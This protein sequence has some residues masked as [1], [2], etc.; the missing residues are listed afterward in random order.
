MIWNGYIHEIII[1][2]FR[3]IYILPYMYLHNSVVVVANHCVY[4]FNVGTVLAIIKQLLYLL[5]YIWIQ[6]LNICYILV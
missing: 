6:L 1:H 5:T 2:L 4:G 3:N